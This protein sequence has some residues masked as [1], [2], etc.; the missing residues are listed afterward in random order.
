MDMGRAKRMSSY[1]S[2]DATTRVV[3]DRDHTLKNGQDTYIVQGCMSF[4]VGN[5]IDE[6]WVHVPHKHRVT[7]AYIPKL[8]RGWIKPDSPIGKAAVIHHYLCE[9]GKVRMKKVRFVVERHEAH[10]VFREA[11]KVAGV[12]L[13]KR[14]V[15]FLSAFLYKEPRMN[16][17]EVD[18]FSS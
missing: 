3:F 7:G 2:F 11:M 9:V 18:A 4:Y 12:C 8:L 17:E 5:R 16:T 13:F 1:R 14:W 15:L 6:Y 10:M